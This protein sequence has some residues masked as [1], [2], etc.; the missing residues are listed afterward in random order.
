[1]ALT[2]SKIDVLSEDVTLPGAVRESSTDHIQ[3]MEAVKSRRVFRFQVPEKDLKTA[4]AAVRKAAEV[5]GMG[6][7]VMSAVKGNTA[8]IQAQ[9]KDRRKYTPRKPKSTTAAK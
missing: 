3:F 7:R 9:G 5:Q 1:M 6:V 4:K 8:G 2:V